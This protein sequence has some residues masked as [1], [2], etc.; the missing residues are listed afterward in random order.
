MLGKEVVDKIFNHHKLGAI[1]NIRKLDVGFCNDVYSIDEKYILK[2]NKPTEDEVNLEKEAFFCD[3]FKNRLPAAEVL[4]F[5][6]SKKILN[7]FFIIYHQIPGDNLYNK[8]HLFDNEQ[9]HDIIKQICVFLK[10]INNT[11]AGS[12]IKRFNV[13][14]NISWEDYIYT[15]INGWLEKFE[16]N[17][18]LSDGV[19]NGVRIFCKE[20]R[21]V[22]SETKMALTYFDAHFDNFIVKDDK[23]VGMLD[24]ERT[25]WL[26][27]DYVL[28]L[29]DRMVKEPK[30]YASEEA[31]N[32]VRDEDYKDLLVMYKECY[33]ELFGFKDFDKRLVIYNVE[34]YLSDI[35]YFPKIKSLR[36]GLD[37][38]LN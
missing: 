2:V 17:K 16:K 9:R 12:Y 4:V 31:E 8:W 14:T 13:N 24:F 7:N 3:L 15:K 33:P 30:K 20:N 34:H 18:V 6:N 19:I 25:D 22:L 35:F 26:S 38:C 21:G 29:V 5:D 27:I 32:Y 37:K 36:E 28:D 11:P 23:I 10:E 1:S